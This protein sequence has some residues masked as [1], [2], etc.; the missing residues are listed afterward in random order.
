[1]Q[2]I[3]SCACGQLRLQVEGEPVRVALCSCLECQRRT[4]SPIAAVA[5]FRRKKVKA[6]NG[7]SKEFTRHS[8][9][10]RWVKNCFCPDCGST[11]YYEAEVIPDETGVPLGAFADPSFP[12]PSIFLFEQSKHPWLPLPENVVVY[13]RGRHGPG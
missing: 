12:A 4:G 2:R 7:I 8:E 5:Y 6:I 13:R 11:T 1:M 9:A 10:N 3:A